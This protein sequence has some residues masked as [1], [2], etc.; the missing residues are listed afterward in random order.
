MVLQCAARPSPA[1]SFWR[2]ASPDALMSEA[3]CDSYTLVP[4]PQVIKQ[5]RHRRLCALHF[6][7]VS[8]LAVHTLDCDF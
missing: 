2:A 6:E 1:E 3:I 7:R 5:D 8:G 4:L